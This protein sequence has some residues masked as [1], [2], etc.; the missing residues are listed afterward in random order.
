MEFIRSLLDLQINRRGDYILSQIP[1][2]KQ[3][4]LL[5]FSRVGGFFNFLLLTQ[6][7]KIFPYL[8]LLFEV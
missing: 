8:F 2:E 5:F 4:S 1:R 6:R 3:F 7:N